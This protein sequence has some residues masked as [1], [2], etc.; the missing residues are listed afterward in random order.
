[1]KLLEVHDLRSEFSDIEPYFDKFTAKYPEFDKLEMIRELLRGESVIWKGDSFFMIGRP[2]KYHNKTIFLIQAA[3]GEGFE[4]MEYL[5]EIEAEI[6]SWGY[7]EIEFYGRL[8][9]QNIMK[10][11]GYTP[12]K[13]VMR[14]EL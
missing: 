1:M 12:I 7:D 10:E 6:K 8:G 3:A 11:R 13:T 4:W 5:P 14:K 2:T 9:W